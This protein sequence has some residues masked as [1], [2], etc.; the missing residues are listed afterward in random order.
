MAPRWQL[1]PPPNLAQW[2]EAQGVKIEE[3][4]TSVNAKDP[5]ETIPDDANDAGV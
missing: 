5:K 1:P 3:L 2:A 4:L